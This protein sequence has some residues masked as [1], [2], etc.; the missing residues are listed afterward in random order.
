[1]THQTNQNHHPSRPSRPL[2]K[3][4]KLLRLPLIFAG[5][6]LLTLGA[7]GEE[8]ERKLVDN[9][10]QAPPPP[11]PPPRAT[12]IDQLMTQYGIDQRIQLPEN[13][14]PRTTAERIAV[15]KFFHS[16]ITG[17]ST[18]LS[19]ML[20]PRDQ[21]ELAA[22]EADGSFQEAV[23]E[24]GGIEIRSGITPNG[25][26][27]VVAVLH[28]YDDF[29]PQ[30]WRYEVDGIDRGTFTSGPTPLNVLDKLSGDNWVNRWYELLDE[31]IAIAMQID[32][33]VAVPQKDVTTETNAKVSGG[34]GPGGPARPASPPD[35]PVVEPPPTFTPGN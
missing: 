17:D 34:G 30:L 15:L 24:L 1:M 21:P 35:R 6:A 25:D 5:A 18:N 33:E 29:H 28:T 19:T 9:T 8:E 7:C 23:S 32:Q 20:S 14:A 26:P 2:S 11:P 31:E 12:S 13:Y 3:R 27:A 4:T 16:M 22:L 10:P